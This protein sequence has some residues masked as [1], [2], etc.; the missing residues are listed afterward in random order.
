MKNIELQAIAKQPNN[1]IDSCPILE[2][3]DGYIR[4]EVDSGLNLPSKHLETDN[5]DDVIDT[6]LQTEQI[7]SSLRNIITSSFKGSKL[8]QIG[9]DVMWK[10]FIECFAEHRPLVLS[11]DMIWLLISQTITRHV[12]RNAEVLRSKFVDFSGQMDLWAQFKSSVEIQS[13][14][15]A[16]YCT[17]TI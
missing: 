10:T 17:Y 3:R 4:F 11:P 9:A 5:P 1:E 16:K 13:Q 15:L 7:D 6:I 2:R 8:S 12:R 14:L